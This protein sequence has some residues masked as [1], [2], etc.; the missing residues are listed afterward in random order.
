M[1][2]TIRFGYHDELNINF[3]HPLDLLILVAI[4]CACPEEIQNIT[5][6][7]ASFRLMHRWAVSAMSIRMPETIVHPDQCSRAITKITGRN[8]LLWI[9]I[10]WIQILPDIL[11]KILPD[12]LQK[13]LPDILQKI[14][15]DILQKILPD[16]FW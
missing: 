3:C 11:Q 10:F 12:I 8:C 14:L 15:P 1:L 6:D 13:I 2:I 7:Q 16:I 4:L 5:N 9:Q